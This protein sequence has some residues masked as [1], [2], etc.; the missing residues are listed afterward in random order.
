MF[1]YHNK[2]LSMVHRLHH[3]FASCQ[4]HK[5]ATVTD[6]PSVKLTATMELLQEATQGQT[7]SVGKHKTLS[8]GQYCFLLFCI[9]KK[10]QQ[11]PNAVTYEAPYQLTGI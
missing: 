6:G 7:L 5:M 3:N 10:K 4:I 11:A 8:P 9:V 2:L 1:E